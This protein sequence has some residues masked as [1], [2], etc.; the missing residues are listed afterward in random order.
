MLRTRKL[1][2]LLQEYPLLQG[3]EWVLKYY[4]L[5]HAGAI[6]SGGKGTAKEKMEVLREAGVEIV[7][8]PTEI[9][10]ILKKIML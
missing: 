10:I 4:D 9:G 8:S 1:S 2:R 3:G 6:I 7:E 5:G